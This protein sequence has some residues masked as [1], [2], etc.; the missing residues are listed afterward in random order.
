M[1][2]KDKTDFLLTQQVIDDG[3][4]TLLLGVE[5]RKYA[6]AGHF[7]REITSLLPGADAGRVATVISAFTRKGIPARLT[8]FFAALL[9]A[10][11]ST[12]LVTP[13]GRRELVSQ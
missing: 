1:V 4:A 9:A 3:E 10:V 2:T 6:S 7:T 12:W 5:E 13:P 11:L 8:T